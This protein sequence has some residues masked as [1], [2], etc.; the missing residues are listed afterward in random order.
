M[1]G[2][3]A[4][5]FAPQHPDWPRCQCGTAW[6]LYCADGRVLAETGL[7]VWLATVRSARCS[8]R[9]TPRWPPSSSCSADRSSRVAPAPARLGTALAGDGYAIPMPVLKASGAAPPRR[10][11]TQTAAARRAT[12]STTSR[13]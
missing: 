4:A 1:L 10:T 9:S 6:Q 12:M 13:A 8:P 11:L 2:A 7:L 5:R 3:S